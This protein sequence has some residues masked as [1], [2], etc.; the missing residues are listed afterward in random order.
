MPA[1][2]SYSVCAELARSSTLPALTKDIYIW[3]G[4]RLWEEAGGEDNMCFKE[5][6]R[7]RI[8]RTEEAE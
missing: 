6:G 4:G 5:A 2:G 1:N 3:G 8:E 7:S